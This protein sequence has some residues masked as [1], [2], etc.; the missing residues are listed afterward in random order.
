MALDLFSVVLAI[1]VADTL[2]DRQRRRVALGRG[3]VDQVEMP[4]V[5]SP[6][7]SI[8]FSRTGPFTRTWVGM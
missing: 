3:G 4:K 5:S 8:A 6:R 1:A 2:V 7:T